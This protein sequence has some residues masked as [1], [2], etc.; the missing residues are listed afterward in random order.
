[1]PLIPYD[2]TRHLLDWRDHPDF[3]NT[4]SRAVTTKS[5]C[6]PPVRM[7]HAANMPPSEDA[8]IFDVIVLGAGL[9]LVVVCDI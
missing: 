1:M 5:S 3:S 6:P 9:S 4:Q 2:P 8:A 7:R